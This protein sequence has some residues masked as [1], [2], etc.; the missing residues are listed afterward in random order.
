MHRYCGKNWTEEDIER[1]RTIITSSPSATRSALSRVICQEFNWLKPDGGLKD[2]SCRVAMLRM[3]REGLIVLPPSTRPPI[4]TRTLFTSERSDPKPTMEIPLDKL[5]NLRVDLVLHKKDL[6]LW[7]EYVSRYH[8]L[9]Y[10]MLPGAQLR[11]L[12]KAGDDVLGAMGLKRS[13]L[14]G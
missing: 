12:I 6:S 2:M 3:H 9:G 4:K 13:S 10:K 14:E 5:I 8:Y 7:N 11:Y 1:I